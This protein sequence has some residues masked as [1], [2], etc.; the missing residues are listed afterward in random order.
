MKNKK[1]QKIILKAAE[2]LLY[3][4]ITMMIFIAIVYAILEM[5]IEASLIWTKKIISI[6]RSLFLISLFL[7]ILLGLIGLVNSFPDK[8]GFFLQ[9]DEEE[10]EESKNE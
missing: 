3:F 4:A 1:L 5:N 6:P 7:V 8:P 2:Y 10:K 9:K